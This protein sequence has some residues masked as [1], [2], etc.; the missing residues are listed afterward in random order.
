MENLQQAGGYCKICQGES[1]SSRKGKH[2]PGDYTAACED[3]SHLTMD[4]N[5]DVFCYELK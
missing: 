1:R 2:H 4:T 3:I 5:F